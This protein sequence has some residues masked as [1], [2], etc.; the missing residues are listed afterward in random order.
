MGAQ[1][2]ALLTHPVVMLADSESDADD[3]VHVVYMPG[4]AKH[5]WA[6]RDQPVSAHTN[7]TVLQEAHDLLQWASMENVS[8][9]AFDWMCKHMHDL[10]GPD[11]LFPKS[12][13]IMQVVIGQ[14]SWEEFQVHVCTNAACAGHSWPV[15]KKSEW[16]D[17]AN[18]V[19]P[20]CDTGRRFQDTG[21]HGR[22]LQPLGYIIYFGLE[23]VIRYRFFGDAKWCSTLG[24][25]DTGPGMALPACF[26]GDKP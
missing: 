20:V 16:A 26:Q 21:P 8:K 17:H 10:L 14:A 4:T 2:S 19:C 25:R 6:N 11:N 15:I 13:H 23:N 12:E 7:R 24:Q 9:R 3:D 22:G 18:D 1:L 5:Y